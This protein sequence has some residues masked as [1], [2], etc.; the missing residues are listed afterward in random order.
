[1]KIK[2]LMFDLGGVIMNIDRMRAVRAL[3]AAGMR[4]PESLLG[5]YG[6]KG[7]F[8]ALERGDI[9]PDEF[10]AQLKPYFD[11]PVTDD[12]IDTAFCEFL[13]GIPVE[14]LRALEELKQRGFN[15]YLLSNTNKVMWDRYILPEFTKDG[16][17]IG[18]YFDGVITSFDV[19][20]YKPEAAIFQAAIDR[21]DID[22][23][24]TV[25]YDDSKANLDG[26]AALGFSTAW[27]T[28]DNPFMNQIPD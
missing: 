16:H 13:T 26:A 4:D 19:K 27:V 7:P 12:E 2:N 17:D 5:D 25:F 9:T 3:A 22:P 14:R 28:D 18:H 6:Q 1:M 20:A 10:H 11:R 8:L 23:A 21:C 24:E 15:I